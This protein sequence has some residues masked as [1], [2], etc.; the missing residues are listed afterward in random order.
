[1]LQ[2]TNLHSG[3]QGLAVL[4]GVSLHVGVAEIVTLIGANGSGKS[5][6]MQTLSGLLT[7]SRGQVFLDSKDITSLPPYEIVGRGL[8]LVPEGRHLF[9]PMTVSDNL[10][11]GAYR[12]GKRRGPSAQGHLEEMYTLFPILKERSR[13]LAG[14]LSG[15]EQQMLAIARGLMSSPR[16]LL[17]D[18]PS[19]GLAPK[20]A[21]E[22]FRKLETLRSTG[23]SVLL[24]EQN[25]RLALGIADRGYVIETGQIV[26]EGSSDDL[27]NNED[28]RRA[29][30]GSGY[31]EVW[32]DLVLTKG[33][34]PSRGWEEKRL[35]LSTILQ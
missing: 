21:A 15:G 13:Q 5:T 9:A 30:M 34:V 11:L 33:I 7:P 12:S 27:L 16:V 2:V 24:V 6:L 35:C 3:Y 19:L 18:E 20:I 14:T 28:V 32:R 22:I 31:R 25:A 17:L 10:I 23:V 1:M 4:H 26:V 29:Y 8:A